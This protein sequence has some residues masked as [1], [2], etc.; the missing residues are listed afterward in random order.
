MSNETRVVTHTPGPYIYEA[1]TG[2]VRLPN[3]SRTESN[4]IAYQVL[5]HNGPMLAA[6]PDMLAALDLILGTATNDG[7]TAGEY[8]LRARMADVAH[9][10][11]SALTAAKGGAR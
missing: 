9:L 5:P 4:V 1:S 6:A 7:G 10:A 2:M 3:G 8:E 11:R